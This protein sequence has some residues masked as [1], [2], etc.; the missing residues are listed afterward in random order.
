M[1]AQ[2]PYQSA[3]DRER[4][5]RLH[6]ES[7]LDEKTRDLYAN[8][9]QLQETIAELSDTQEKLIQS[10]KM[11]SIGQ[12][13]AGVAHEINN[14]I[15]F[16]I[17]NLATLSDCVESFMNLDEFVSA[18]MA[19]NSDDNF[20]EQ[21]KNLQEQEDIEF[22]KEDVKELLSDTI[23][24]LDRVKDIVAHLKKVSYQGEMAKELCDINACIEESLKV[25]G[26]ELKY[27]MEVEKDLQSIPQVMCHGNE[28]H[29][30]LINMYV[31]AAHACEDNPQGLLKVK[32]SSKTLRKKDWVVIDITDNGK[33][34]SKAIIKKIFDPFYTTKPVGVG[35]GLGLSISFGIIEK[36]GG[37]IDVVSEEGKG[38]T[39]SI[40]LPVEL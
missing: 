24:G 33:G 11:A 39:F 17:S 6:A 15:G 30:V 13:A 37:R 12:L 29:Q 20:F 36:H 2:N 35:T 34:I 40:L 32:T 14:P 9:V 23:N 7:L 3:Y 18:K 19:T 4:K 5:A 28:L 25:A 10:E 21:Y 8:V 38:T 31:N 27:T 22:I 16:S 1:D 26:S